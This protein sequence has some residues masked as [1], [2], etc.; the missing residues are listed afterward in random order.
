M[1]ILKMLTQLEKLET[2]MAGLYEWFS[3]VFREDEAAA[4]FFYG[5]SVEEEV[6]ANIVRY[7][8]RLV[9][10]NIK[11]FSEVDFDLTPIEKTLSDI[12]AIRKTEILPSLE[13]A[14]RYAIELEHSIAEEHYRTILKKANP[15]IEGLLK[16]LGAFDLRHLHSFQEFVEKRGGSHVPF[17]SRQNTAEIRRSSGPPGEEREEESAGTDKEL[18]EKIDY[19]HTWYRSMDYYKFF[20]IREHATGQQIRHAYSRIAKEYHPDM[21]FNMSEDIKQKLTDI[22]AYAVD[23]YATLSSPQRRQLYDAERSSPRRH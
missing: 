7:Q 9:S 10:Q 12:A 23:A 17:S 20:D 13:E 8:R 5:V 4:A 15:E 18:L 11:N 19:L 22:F 21:H 16:S 6:H 14:L 2:N 1:Q 3:H